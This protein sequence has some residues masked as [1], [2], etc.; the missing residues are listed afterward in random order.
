MNRDEKTLPS[1]LGA[2][3]LGD[4]ILDTMKKDLR[5]HHSLKLDTDEL[6]HILKEGV[7]KQEIIEYLRE[8]ENRRKSEDRRQNSI[9]VENDRR[10]GDDR[11][12]EDNRTELQKR[13]QELEV[14][15]YTLTTDP[16]RGFV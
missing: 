15:A 6:R 3:I 5:R 12:V 1:L 10:S 16:S 13:L 8:N 2:I 11:R 14:S 9:K 4:D 7:L